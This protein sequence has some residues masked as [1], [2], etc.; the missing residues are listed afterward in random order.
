M[1]KIGGDLS[2]RAPAPGS[3]WKL[4]TRPEI[5]PDHVDQ[6]LRWLRVERIE[7]LEGNFA[8][9]GLRLTTDQRDRLDRL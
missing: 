3:E 4:D 5:L 1:F 6:A 7:H 2:V 9:A 8:A